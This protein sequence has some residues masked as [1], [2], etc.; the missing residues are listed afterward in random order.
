[1]LLARI[2]RKHLSGK[3]ICSKAFDVTRALPRREIASA[4][5]VDDL[6]LTYGTTTQ[7]ALLKR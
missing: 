7:S 1:L 5:I 4:L 2:A 6:L 3:A